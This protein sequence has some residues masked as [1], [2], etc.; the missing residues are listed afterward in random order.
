MNRGRF[1][2]V[3]VFV[4]VGASLAN[5]APKR[6]KNN[7]RKPPI[8]PAPAREAEPEPPPPPPADD[9]PWGKGVSAENKATAQRLLGEGNELFVVDKVREALTKYEAAVAAWDHPAI[10]FNMV[11]AQISL[12]LWLDAKRSLDKALAF[13]KGP[14]EDQMYTEALNYKRLLAGQTAEY[15][16]VCKQPGVKVKVDGVSVIDCPGTKSND[17]APGTHVIVGLKEGY[18]THTQDVVLLPGKK[19]PIVIELITIQKATLYKSRWTTWKPW[20]IV[21]GGVVV[22]GLGVL[23][24]RQA[25]SDMD[26]LESAVT[27]SCPSGCT[28]EEYATFGHKAAEDRALSEN[29]IAIGMIAAGGAIVVGGVIAVILNRP[30][31]YISEQRER[32]PT[33]A[34][35][36]T[37]GADG[38]GVAVLGRF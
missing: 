36:P 8:A 13:G 34:I 35:V 11:R 27:T 17:A 5:A 14:L 33:T 15:E 22:A 20:A 26:Q 29:R 32:A 9:T 1:R 7:D 31:P 24:N 18:L 25:F 21:G 28:D 30:R 19:Q 16:V 12:Q 38:G 23:L 3:V 2:W 10:R 37:I 6:D 4:M